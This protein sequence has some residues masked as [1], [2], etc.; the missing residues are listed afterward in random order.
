MLKGD[1]LAQSEAAASVL[2]VSTGGT[3]A[4]ASAWLA[5][6]EK[7]SDWIG[8]LLKDKPPTHDPADVFSVGDLAVV[9]TQQ[10]LR[11]RVVGQVA[12]GQV[13]LV[14]FGEHDLYMRFLR[15]RVARIGA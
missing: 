6:Y 2:R 8:S 9:T 15:D 7:W 12:P 4:A 14:D 1:A 13:S 10:P 3:A 11:L 5:K